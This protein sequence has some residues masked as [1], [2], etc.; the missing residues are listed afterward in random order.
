MNATAY[1]AAAYGTTLCALVLFWVRS[2]RQRIQ[3]VE[4]QQS[5]LRTQT[6]QS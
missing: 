5:H 3:L 2:I 1:I 6:T 4:M